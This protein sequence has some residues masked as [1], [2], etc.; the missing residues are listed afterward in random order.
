MTSGFRESKFYTGSVIGLNQVSRFQFSNEVCETTSDT[1]FGVYRDKRNFFFG[2]KDRI[3]AGAG[4]CVTGHWNATCQVLVLGR[5]PIVAERC[6]LLFSI[7]C[8]RFE[9]VKRSCV[10]C[11][12]QN[13]I[14]KGR[15]VKIA[16]SKWYFL[17]AGMTLSFGYH[18]EQKQSVLFMP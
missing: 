1:G 15:C 16:G 4:G 9:T 2:M 14:I 7:I 8:Q 6:C 13:I 11:S 12:R 10:R 5:L 3:V 18:G 17:N